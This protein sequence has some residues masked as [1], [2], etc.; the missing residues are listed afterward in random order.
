MLAGIIVLL[1]VKIYRLVYLE[2]LEQQQKV[3]PHSALLL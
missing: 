3:L 2:Q 1:R